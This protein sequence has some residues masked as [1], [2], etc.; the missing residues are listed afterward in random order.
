MFAPT[1]P[2][3]EI[4]PS[5]AGG[6]STERVRVLGPTVGATTCDDA[7][8]AALAG[9]ALA[10]VDHSVD[11]RDDGV[12]DGGYMQVEGT[13]RLAHRR[14]SDVSLITDTGLGRQDSDVPLL[15]LAD[16]TDPGI[17]QRR[18]SSTSRL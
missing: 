17:V 5:S 9:G 6:L 10:I 7:L 2:G 3:A 12:D 18:L 1:P 11:H 16:P 4:G 13:S 8:P 15:D 14:E